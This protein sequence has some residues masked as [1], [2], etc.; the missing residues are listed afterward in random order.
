ML[1]IMTIISLFVKESRVFLGVFVVMYITDRVLGA[2]S[3]RYGM[4][5]DGSGAC[6]ARVQKMFTVSVA[7]AC[8]CAC[9]RVGVGSCV[10]VCVG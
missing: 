10:V 4:L 8:M 5:K 7:C 6:V 3:V 2:D 9:V 1:I